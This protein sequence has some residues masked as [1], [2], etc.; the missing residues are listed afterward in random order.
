MRGGLLQKCTSLSEVG[1]IQGLITTNEP[2]SSRPRPPLQT[3]L[4]PLF[5]LSPHPSSI[6]VFT[7]TQ[8]NRTKGENDPEPDSAKLNTAVWPCLP[9]SSSYQPYWILLCWGISCSPICLSLFKIRLQNLQIVSFLL[10]Q[11]ITTDLS[12]WNLQR[13]AWCF[14]CCWKNRSRNT[15]WTSWSYVEVLM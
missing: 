12:L 8:T 13:A 7:P 6:V 5:F 9:D 14:A 2:Y 1:A 3:G 4:G 10:Q 15:L 11:F